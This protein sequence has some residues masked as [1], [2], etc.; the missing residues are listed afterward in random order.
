MKNLSIIN[1]N[2]TVLHWYFKAMLA[3]YVL[4][5]VGYYEYL[6]M[7]FEEYKVLLDNITLKSAAVVFLFTGIFLVFR[8][9]FG[10]G[11]E[12]SKSET[13]LGHLALLMF[14]NIE[15][16][17]FHAHG[18]LSIKHFDLNID[19]IIAYVNWLLVLNLIVLTFMHS[20]MYAWGVGAIV[21]LFVYCNFVLGTFI[22][23]EGNHSLPGHFEFWGL[24]GI[25]LFVFYFNRIEGLRRFCEEKFFA[26]T[27]ALTK[28]K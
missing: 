9:N 19:Q 12:A 1:I 20:K 13:F 10:Y 22:E 2:N 3:L 11:K 28:K 26:K 18:V 4:L 17:Y 5:L 15:L 21:L 16:I 27:T 25:Y 23:L 6:P 8:N 24:L 14:I 7:G